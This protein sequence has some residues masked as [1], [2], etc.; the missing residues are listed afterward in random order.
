[1]ELWLHFKQDAIDRQVKNNVEDIM[2]LI[3]RMDDTQRSVEDSSN[4]MRLAKAKIDELGKFKRS[5]ETLRSDI[6]QLLEERLDGVRRDIR[7]VLRSLVRRFT[8][9]PFKEYGKN[10]FTGYK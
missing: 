6:V 5:A 10:T 4:T 7:V 3:K 9:E 1:M 2:V 8:A